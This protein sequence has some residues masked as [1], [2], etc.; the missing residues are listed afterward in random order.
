M[1]SSL[2][3]IGFIKVMD[4]HEYIEIHHKD[5]GGWII[6]M[7]FKVLLIMQILIREILVETVLGIYARDVKIKNFS[8]QML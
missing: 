4:V 2:F 6:V 8:I 7:D 5:C 3:D 1:L